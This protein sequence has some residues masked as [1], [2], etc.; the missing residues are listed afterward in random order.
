MIG[1]MVTFVFL[2]AWSAIGC[3]VAFWI[4]DKFARF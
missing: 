2:M 1:N 3:L 4:A